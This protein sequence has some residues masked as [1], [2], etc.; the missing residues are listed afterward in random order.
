MPQMAPLNWFILFIIFTIALIVLSLLNYY[1]NTPKTIEIKPT[2]S[3]TYKI[4][5]KW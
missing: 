2:I 5:W 1:Q 4:N 3:S